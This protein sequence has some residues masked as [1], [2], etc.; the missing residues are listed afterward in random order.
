MDTGHG[1]SEVRGAAERPEARA[2]GAQL[3]AE[4][5]TRLGALF[6]EGWELWDRF[7]TQVRRHHFHPF[8][9]ADYQVVLEALVPMRAPGLK[10]LEWGSAT[11]VIAIMADLLGFDAYGI[12]ID[13]DLVDQARD[14]AQR[15]GSRA[16]FIAGSFIPDGYRWRDRRGDERLGTIGDGE[17]AYLQLGMPL[18]EFDVVFGYPWSGEEP[19]MLDLM[20]VHGRAGARF[21]IHTAGVVQIHQGGQPV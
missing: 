4:L 17:S 15:T 19:M 7:D 10:F 6:D 5:R 9:A 14:L 21:L 18:E 13:P 16:R 3:D 1:G 2:G 12:E 20:R 8:V 11:G